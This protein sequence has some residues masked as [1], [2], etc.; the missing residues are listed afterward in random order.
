[1]PSFCLFLGGLILAAYWI[2]DRLAEGVIG[3]AVL[4]T[5]GLVF[6][7]GTRSDTLRGLG[8]PGRDERWAFIDTAATAFAGLV[9]IVATIGLWLYEIA[10]GGDGSPYAQLCAVAGLSYIA[11]VA[12]LRVRR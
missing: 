2:G 7:V 6:L 10:D 4:A 8:G 9:L 3:F 11:A 12:W 1:M 5:L